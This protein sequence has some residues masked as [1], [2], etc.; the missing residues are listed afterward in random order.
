MFVKTSVVDAL[1]SQGASPN[2][3][4]AAGDSIIH[5]AIK[6][7][8]LD[9]VWSSLMVLGSEIDRN[10]RDARGNTALHLAV[11]YDI[12]N[13]HNLFMKLLQTGWDVNARNHV[14]R[15]HIRTTNKCND[16]IFLR[17]SFVLFCRMAQLQ[18][19]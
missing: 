2:Y 8:V 3:K 1:L 10:L 14:K 4:N 6:N 13:D 11:E 12:Y 17:S 18:C 7:Q 19:C 16:S 5:I 9:T 15:F